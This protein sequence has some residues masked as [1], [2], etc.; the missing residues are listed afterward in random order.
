MV[1]WSLSVAFAFKEW[2]QGIHLQKKLIEKLTGIQAKSDKCL[3]LREILRGKKG[4]GLDCLTASEK[5]Q[6][7]QQV[8]R[9]F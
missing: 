7:P 1:P 2:G 6:N 8:K 3:E 9:G 5:K 4:L